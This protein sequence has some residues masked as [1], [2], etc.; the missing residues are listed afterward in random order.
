VS[1]VILS[2]SG[3][4]Y[5]RLAWS[6][7]HDVILESMW[8]WNDSSGGGVLLVTW[9][10]LND[11]RTRSINT[12]ICHRTPPVVQEVVAGITYMDLVLDEVPT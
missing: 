9:T 6:A 3:G 12:N 7:N 2:G 4:V 8:W 1:Q 11:A 5:Q 10:V